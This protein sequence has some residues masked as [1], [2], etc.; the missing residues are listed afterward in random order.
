MTITWI[1][2]LLNNDI[3][4]QIDKTTEDILLRIEILDILNSLLIESNW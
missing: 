2:Y 1:D 3:W 4:D